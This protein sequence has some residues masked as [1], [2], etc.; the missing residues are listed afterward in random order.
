[1]ILD[2]RLQPNPTNWHQVDDAHFTRKQT[3]KVNDSVRKRPVLVDDSQQTTIQQSYLLDKELTEDFLEKTSLRISPV[4]PPSAI[5]SN[6]R[7]QPIVCFSV[8]DYCSTI[9]SKAKFIKRDELSDLLNQL[10]LKLSNA[11][12]NDLPEEKQQLP[13]LVDILEA[14]FHVPSST[15]SAVSQNDFFTLLRLPLID[16]LQHWSRGGALSEVHL[17]IFHHITKLIELLID[18]IGED[19]R[20]PLWLSDL[21]LLQTIAQCLV[22]IASSDTLLLPHNKHHFKYFTRLIDAYIDYQQRLIQPS[23]SDQDKLM[24]L[25]DPILRCLTSNHY[26]DT[27]NDMPVDQSSM[28]TKQK[29]FLVKCPTFLT[30]YTG[31][32]LVRFA[33]FSF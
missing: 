10:T 24:P 4:V 33:L 28:S 29:F 15:L 11:S 26:I 25:I 9:Y 16:F 13:F 8:T 22:N 6:N 5:L 2:E 21:T 7:Q 18:N 17:T 27:L 1:M 19:A 12:E 31:S 3:Y 14:L 23:S 32:V 20:L 30:S